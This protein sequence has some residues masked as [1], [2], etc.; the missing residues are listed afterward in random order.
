MADELLPQVPDREWRL[1]QMVDRASRGFGHSISWMIATVVER[2]NGILAED[3]L[4]PICPALALYV[5]FGVDSP[6]ALQLITRSLRSRDVA[7]RVA[8]T[9]ADADIPDEAVARWLALVPIERWGELFGARPADVLDLLD[10]ISDPQA[11]ILRRLLDG[12]A[13]ELTVEQ[14]LTPGPV[15]LA[16]VRDAT[17]VPL[18]SLQTLGGDH[19]ATVGGQWQT[20]LRTVLATGVDL[21]AELTGSTTLSLR[22]GNA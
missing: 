9:A 15:R 8:Q 21:V 3:N 1:E 18:V 7:V 12:E 11:E 6:V 2:A 4:D 16:V 5:R 17:D 22:R 19:L 20:D 13:V 14:A 10:A